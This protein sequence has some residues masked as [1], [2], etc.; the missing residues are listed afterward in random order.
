MSSEPAPVSTDSLTSSCLADALEPD[1]Q[2]AGKVSAHT[3]NT[4][5]LASPNTFVFKFR[6]SVVIATSACVIRIEGAIGPAPP[7]EA[8]VPERREYRKNRERNEQQK[9]IH[10]SRNALLH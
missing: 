5:A 1:A 7:L 8:E 4:S 10:D 2:S 6:R 3:N 9:Q